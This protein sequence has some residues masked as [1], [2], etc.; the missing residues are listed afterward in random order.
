ML[1]WELFILSLGGYDLWKYVS[2]ISWYSGQ[3]VRKCSTVSTSFGCTVCYLKHS[4][5][6]ASMNVTPE[7]G[8]EP[9]T[10]RLK[11]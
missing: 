1:L 5:S 11:V 7:Q 6:H 3:V 4:H 9:W 10:L 2:L 8:L